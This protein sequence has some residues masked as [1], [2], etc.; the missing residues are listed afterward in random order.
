[1]YEVLGVRGL[2]QLVSRMFGEPV[3]PSS[4]QLRR[5]ET[6]PLPGVTM[7]SAAVSCERTRY[8]EVSNL[9]ICLTYGPLIVLCASL[10]VA[11]AYYALVLFCLHGLLVLIERY[12]RALYGLYLN[13]L[14]TA[15]HVPPHPDTRTAPQEAAND[16]PE[17]RRSWYFTPHRF[18]TERLYRA[19]G[20]ERVRQLVITFTKLTAQP[21]DQ[22]GKHPRSIFGTSA[23]CLAEFDAETRVS[24]VSHLIGAILHAPFLVLF[25]VRRS[26][27][28]LFYILLLLCLDFSFVL[29]QRA[30]RVRVW[31]IMERRRASRQ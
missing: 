6:T 2:Y 9:V 16:G 17:R 25:L 10:K 24:E 26:P 8:Y 12:K 1:L 19:I 5:R 20:M 3:L 30:T 22:R 27:P 23:D 7:E 14:P 21:P 15:G 13:W 29:L 4:T 31:R 11:L 18:E 28:G